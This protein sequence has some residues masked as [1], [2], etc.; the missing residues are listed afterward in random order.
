VA[1]Y[2]IYIIS[3]KLLL[4]NGSFVFCK[5]KISPVQNKTQLSLIIHKSDYQLI[6]KYERFKKH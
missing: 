6:S 2:F 1:Y 3:G 4:F 5:S